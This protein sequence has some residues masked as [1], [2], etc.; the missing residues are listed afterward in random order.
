MR[1]FTYRYMWQIKG[2]D[3]VNMKIVTDIEIGLIEFEKA[4]LLV[5]GI[6][7]AAK[8]Y[9]HEYD[10]TLMGRFETLLGGENNEA[11]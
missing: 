11:V 6:E 4:L 3:K 2:S 5:E 8:E 7:K 10:C 9:L 1:I